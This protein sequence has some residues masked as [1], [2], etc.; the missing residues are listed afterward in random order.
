MR[1]RI[2]FDSFTSPHGCLVALDDVTNGSVDDRRATAASGVRR[3]AV[4]RGAI[5]AVARPT[6]G[7]AWT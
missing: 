1:K 3:S 5:G 6:R 2:T 4:N 7:A